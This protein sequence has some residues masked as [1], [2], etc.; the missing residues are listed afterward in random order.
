[1][2]ANKIQRRFTGV[3]MLQP[4]IETVFDIQ[5]E[6]G[7]YCE[8]EEVGSPGFSFRIAMDLLCNLGEVTR[9]CAAAQFAA[10]KTAM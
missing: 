8:W 9:P 2:I 5:A 3:V 10:C 1:M 4:P 6:E 7:D